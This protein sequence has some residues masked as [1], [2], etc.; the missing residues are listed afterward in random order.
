D[1]TPEDGATDASTDAIADAGAD[2]DAETDADAEAPLNVIYASFNG[3]LVRIDPD[4]AELTEVGPLET[5]DDPPVACSDV[6]MPWSREGDLAY[7]ITDYDD[8]AF[9]TVNLCTAKVS[10]GA[11]ISRPS[12]PNLVVEGLAVDAEGTVF[13]AAGNPANIA[14]PLSD[15]LGTLNVETGVI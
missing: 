10:V 4:T 5:D 7:M 6:V 14:S 13:V 3:V 15:H 11:T 2:A 8:A 9:A 12:S 1:A